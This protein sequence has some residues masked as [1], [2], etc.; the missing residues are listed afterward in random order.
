MQHARMAP[1]DSLTTRRST[2]SEIASAMKKFGLKGKGSKAKAKMEAKMEQHQ[3]AKEAKWRDGV[4]ENPDPADTADVKWKSI[5]QWKEHQ[6]ASGEDKPKSKVVAKAEEKAKQS[7]LSK[8]HTGITN[9]LF[10][11]VTEISAKLLEAA[12]PAVRASNNETGGIVNAI[13]GIVI[14]S[15]LR[16]GNTKNRWIYLLVRKVQPLAVASA[17]SRA[18]QTDPCNAD[19][20]SCPATIAR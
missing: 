10:L 16:T 4:M 3:Q 19:S 15:H 17:A 14:A 2:C 8:V 1:H 6:A 12:E 9:K 5:D 13:Q 11:T 7:L 20:G 18:G